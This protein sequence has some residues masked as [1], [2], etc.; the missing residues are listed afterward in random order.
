MTVPEWIIS[1]S[2]VFELCSHTGS[3]LSFVYCEMLKIV[4]SWS[5]L[6]WTMYIHIHFHGFLDFS[7]S[8][9]IHWHLERTD[10]LTHWDL[11]AYL[12]TE[13]YCS[14]HRPSNVALWH[15]PVGR[16]Y[17]TPPPISQMGRVTL[18]AMMGSPIPCPRWRAHREKLMGWSVESLVPCA[19]V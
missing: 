17:L 4:A 6:K 5:G 8:N 1:A 15:F 7:L 2:S 10:V 12:A 14:V 11:E 18:L 3:H 19:G 16:F 9:K 13:I